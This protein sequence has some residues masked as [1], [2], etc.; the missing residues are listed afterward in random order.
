MNYFVTGGTGFFGKSLVEKLLQREGTRNTVKCA[1]DLQAGCIQHTKS[2]AVSGK[3]QGGFR[4][5]IFEQVEQVEPSSE[6]VAIA[7]LLKGVHY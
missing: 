5:G 3:Y 6:Q 7:A 2:I 1:E 4:E